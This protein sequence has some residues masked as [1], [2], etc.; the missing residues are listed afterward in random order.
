MNQLE[1][2]LQYT[3]SCLLNVLMNSM[4]NICNKHFMPTL[5]SILC[6]RYGV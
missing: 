6:L 5:W 1:F 4:L 2:S 3:I